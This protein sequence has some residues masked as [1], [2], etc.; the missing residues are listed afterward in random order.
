MPPDPKQTQPTPPADPA[1]PPAADI[2]GRV[3]KIETE[4]TRQGGMLEQILQRLPG[5][6]PGT[7]KAGSDPAPPPAPGGKSVA[8]LVREGIEALEAEKASKAEGD[9]NRTAREEHAARIKALEERAPAETAASPVGAFRARAQR[10]LFGI[11]EP[12]K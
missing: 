2:A 5:S 6:S 9:A 3:D 10:A 4:Q 8:E 11:D 1:A 12:H 7:P